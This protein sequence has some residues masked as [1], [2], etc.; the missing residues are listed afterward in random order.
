[1]SSKKAK[2]YSKDESDLKNSS[3]TIIF[4]HRGASGY[5]YEN[6]F[7]SFNKALSIKADGLETDCWLLS[8]GE[9]ALYH[10]KFI[11]DYKSGKS[12]NISKMSLNEIK[13][14]DL[15]N[16]EKIPTL[17]EFFEEYGDKKTEDNKPILF[18]IDLQDLEV[19]M[20]IIPI[21]EE[22]GVIEQTYLCGSSSIKLA[23]VR[24]VDNRVKLVASNMQNRIKSKNLQ[25]DSKISKLR[26][27]A[28]NIQADLFEPE[29]ISILKKTS[30]Q[31][32]IWD[33]HTEPLLRKFLNFHPYA[34]Y[35]NYPD[36]ALRIRN[37][38]L[39]DVNKIK[40]RY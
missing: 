4:A 31:F 29:M 27:S 15:P 5:E 20:K 24:K 40:K 38:V 11:E 18:S 17:K 13:K 33:L 10:N 32:F 2:G 3:K 6:S 30:I 16:G 9:I 22:Y 39:E 8:D 7:A 1:M 21:L 35:S 37:E 25:P 34:I 28:F 19:G 36:I 14:I 12:F 23:K 26:I